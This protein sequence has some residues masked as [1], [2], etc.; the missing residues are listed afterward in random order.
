MQADGNQVSFEYFL[1]Y[2]A[3]NFLLYHLLH[4]DTLA[5]KDSLHNLE[6][7]LLSKVRFEILIALRV[8]YPID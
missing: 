6:K 8:Q 4:G 2:I 3:A 7:I 1:D 5:R